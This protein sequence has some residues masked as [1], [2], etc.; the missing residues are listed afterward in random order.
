MKKSVVYALILSAFAAPVMAH[1]GHELGGIGTGLLHPL[2]GLDH[3]T[4]MLLVGAWAGLT[5]GRL[6]WLPVVTFPLF[7]TV[8]AALGY[9]GI[10][11]AGIESGIAGSVL[12]MGLLLVGLVR[13]PVAAASLLVALF[14]I[15]H[16]S[17]HGT[18]MPM[19][20]QPWAYALGFVAA[21]AALHLAGLTLAKSLE[22]LQATAVLRSVGALAGLFGAWLVWA[23]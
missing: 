17:A 14:A 18:E 8:G 7:M 21:T 11:P 5:C 2:M 20:A 13:L 10:A 15:L 22:Q 9:A 3:L 16:G 6:A 12:V 23:A 4:V 1:P 19:A